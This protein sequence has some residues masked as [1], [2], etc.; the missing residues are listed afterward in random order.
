[1]TNEVESW[2]SLFSEYESV[3]VLHREGS[4]IRFRLS[5]K[6]DADGTTWTW[7]SDR[8]A[9]EQNRTVHAHRVETGPFRFM[10]IRWFYTE[11]GTGTKMRWAQEFSMRPDAKV[12]DETMA[13]H[14][15]RR[16]VAQM[17]HVK[18]KVEEEFRRSP[19]ARA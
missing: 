3:N 11:S 9:D 8:T 5:T 16:T 13:E 1:M 17:A 10:N 7:V 15:Q 14:L 4:T 18:K 2:P 6:P 19:R 12:D